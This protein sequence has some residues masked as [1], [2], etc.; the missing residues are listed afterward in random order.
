[1]EHLQAHGT[2]NDN[3][4]RE[5]LRSPLCAALPVEKAQDRFTG[6]C[7]GRGHRHAFVTKCNELLGLLIEKFAHSL[8]RR[9]SHG[10]ETKRKRPTDT[11]DLQLEVPKIKKSKLAGLHGIQD[12]MRFTKSSYTMCSVAPFNRYASNV[13][14]STDF[15]RQTGAFFF[16][17]QAC[18]SANRRPRLRSGARTHPACRINPSQRKR[19]RHR[20]R[21]AQ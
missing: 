12:C 14:C 18:A 6:L 15:V 21:R 3:W 20:C 17:N 16:L 19:W 10:F 8:L 11:H 5:A 4:I 7:A 9:S 1:M 2:N 13:L